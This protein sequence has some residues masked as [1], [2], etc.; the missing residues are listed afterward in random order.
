MK[1]FRVFAHRGLWRNPEDEN[2]LAALSRALASGF[3]I[4]TDLRLLNGEFVIKH[5]EPLASESLPALLD[6][7]ALMQDYPERELALHFKYDDWRDPE[8]F[9]VIDLLQPI[10]EQVFLFDMSVEFCEQLKNRDAAIRVGVSVGDKRYHEAFADLETALSSN[11]DVIWADEFREFY[12]PEVITLCHRANK[13]VYCISPDL[14]ASIG[15]PRAHVGYREVWQN[16]IQ[17]GADGICTD[18]SM[19]LR[20]TYADNSTSS[21]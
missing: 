11:I 1:P 13:L 16:L 3:D 8:S 10:K 14:A 7:V 9:A 6:A 17:W 18:Q 19:E 5:D 4:E 20:K 2:S 21:R 15:H 12:H